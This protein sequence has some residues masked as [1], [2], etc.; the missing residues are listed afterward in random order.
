MVNMAARQHEIVYQISMLVV[1][2]EEK[3]KQIYRN[4]R[5]RTS[6]FGDTWFG[7]AECK[8]DTDRIK[9]CTGMERETGKHGGMRI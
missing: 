4:V 7:Y 1:Y 3:K 2:C 5:K 8:N 6:H 9:H